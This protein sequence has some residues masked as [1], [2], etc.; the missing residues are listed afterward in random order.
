MSNLPLLERTELTA[1]FHSPDL[2]PVAQREARI[3]TFSPEKKYLATAGLGP[4]IALVLYNVNTKTGAL[5]H[6]DSM[7]GLED[8]ENLLEEYIK[9]AGRENTV[10]YLVGGEK[11]KSE[12]IIERIQNLLSLHKIGIKGA[13]LLNRSHE[14]IVL[15]LETGTPYKIPPKDVAAFAKRIKPMTPEE[16]H[17]AHL[18]IQS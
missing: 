1:D 6:L 16:L 15:D 18:T 11:D 4:C 3:S 5:A 7:T 2:I 10:A 13:D 8:E 9:K 14:N 12:D 17:R